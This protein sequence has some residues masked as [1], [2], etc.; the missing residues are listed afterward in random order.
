MLL[1][2]HRLQIGGDSMIG[3]CVSRNEQVVLQ[4]VGERVVRFENPLLPDTQSELALPMRARGRVIG[5]MT[6]QS[7]REAAFDEQYISSLQTV[8]DQVAGT[9]DN[10][11]L[12]QQ[13]Q[14]GA[15]LERR[16]YGELSREAWQSLLRAQPDLGYV[17]EAGGT[18]PVG[19]LWEPQMEAAL[20]TGEAAEGPQGTATFSIPIRVR[21]QVVGVVDGRKPDGTAWSSEELDLLQVMGE[22]LNVALEGA[23]LYRDAQR[24]E[25]RERTIGQV[26]TSVRQS[27]EMETMLR[28]AADEIR[29]AMGLGKVVVRLATPPKGQ[30]LSS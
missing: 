12:F 5:A 24:R 3:Q 8:A 25:A 20:G 7:D 30:G 1:Q 2:G 26:T 6:V 10:A 21:G 22:Q 18:V 17:S 14:E 9:L 28:T 29:R 16:A 11:R 27:L 4:G 13:V 19:N 15:E 23:Q